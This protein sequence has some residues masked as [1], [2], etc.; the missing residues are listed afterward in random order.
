MSK[1]TVRQATREDIAAFSDMVNKPTVRAWCAECE[2]E[3]IALAGF[4]LFGGR[5]YAFADLPEKI[6]PRKMLIMRAAKMIMAEARKQGI[7]FIYAEA[8]MN[9]PNAVAWL[10]SL[11]FQADTRSE[12]LYR[13]SVLND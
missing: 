12:R 7:R 2:G 4:A 11:G 6:R 9:E 1:V 10:A 13:W 3:I 5:W 8:D